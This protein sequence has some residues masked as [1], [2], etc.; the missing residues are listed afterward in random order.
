MPTPARM[1]AT[2]RQLN[3]R[4][5]LPPSPRQ[6]LDRL[7]EPPPGR[8]PDHVAGLEKLIGPLGCA[9]PGVGALLVDEEL[10]GPVNIAIGG[11]LCPTVWR[12]KY[13]EKEAPEARSDRKMFHILTMGYTK[14]L[15]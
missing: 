10:G 15:T 3:A 5:P 9:Q 4:S 2:W 14:V 13:R 8:G 1:R 12:L 6:L 11:H 7:E